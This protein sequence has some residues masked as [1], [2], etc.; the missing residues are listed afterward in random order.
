VKFK[1]VTISFTYLLSI[2]VAVVKFGGIFSTGNCC[3]CKQ[4][5]CCLKS[6]SW[7]IRTNKPWIESGIYPVD[8]IIVL[9][10]LCNHKIFQS[11]MSYVFRTLNFVR[12]V[13]W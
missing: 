3:W 7:V 9:G 8:K 1:K 11:G 4:R 6:Y 13:H 10:L 2:A 12:W 5:E